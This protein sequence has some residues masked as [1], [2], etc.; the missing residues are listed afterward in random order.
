MEM[1]RWGRVG[2]NGRGM[3]A[4]GVET[5]AAFGGATNDFVTD[6][7][8][9]GESKSSHLFNLPLT[10]PYFHDHSLSSLRADSNVRLN[11]TCM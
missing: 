6:E 9:S 7:P 2:K 1:V 3:V 11:S 4:T 10:G 5:T 8:G